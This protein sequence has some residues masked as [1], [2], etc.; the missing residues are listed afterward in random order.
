[1]CKVKVN[2][3]GEYFVFSAQEGE[4]LLKLLR[5]NG[6]SIEAPC[7]G[8]GICG[9]CRI[10]LISGQL[11]SMKSDEKGLLGDRAV[12]KGYRLAC[13]CLIQ[14]DI[15]IL[16][17]GVASEAKIVTEGR[18]R[19]LE[20][21]P[22][23]TKIHSI[24]GKPGLEDQRSDL[25]RILLSFEEHSG[26]TGHLLK[27]GFLRELPEILRRRDFNV[28]LVAE[29]SDIIAIESG[30]TSNS[31]YG[32]AFDIG[33]TTIAAYL[34]DLTTGKRLSV[35]SGMNPQRAYGADVISRINHTMQNDDGLEQLN[36]LLIESINA[37]IGTLCEQTGVKTA[38]I[39]AISF[40][41]NTTMLHLLLG[42]SP[43]SIA[44]A[45]FIP[46]F[47]SA[48]RISAQELGLSINQAGI[49]YILPGVSAYVGADTVGAV[50]ST[51]IHQQ[52]DISLLID[53]GTNG[54]IV[55]GNRDRLLACSAAAGP[56]FEGAN[57]SNGMGSIIGAVSS[58]SLKQGVTFKTI[59]DAKPVG[60]CGTG[61]VD[62]LAGL[63]ETGIVDET[64]RIYTSWKPE[65][66]EQES[67]SERIVS[68]NGANAFVLC[69]ASETLTGN[70]IVLTQKDIREIQNAKA[71]IAVG[72]NVLVKNSGI[73]MSDIK[74]VYLAGGF[75]SY[76]NIRSALRIGLI[77]RELEGKIESVGNA[78]GQGAI[79]ALINKNALEEA[80]KLGKTIKYI[81]LSG[82]K[83]F[84][85]LYME[86]MM[87]E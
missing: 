36:S 8:S 60:I 11:S 67:L 5:N 37:C 80:G 2:R 45:P 18:Q 41:G 31:L 53:I 54:E 83:D 10:K 47:T 87:F 14:S 48:V 69:K 6:I 26:T 71:A 3:S 39:Y 34:L 77:P 35:T 21:C 63:L 49:A 50:L 16:I 24:P 75:G 68:I 55:L 62:L 30:D 32:I 20:L 13:F 57:I 79:D 58:V 1:M 73:S 76:I 81:E 19:S 64:G 29:G 7:N 59:G 78:A 12:E 70:E 44:A 28:T 72:I 23:V 43:R 51:G 27:P 86:C 74:H 40:A 38:D 9:K 46:V 4:N 56:A 17:E 84:N 25:D 33:T 52:A 65:F 15:E 66:P 42:V 82:C 22:L 85:D 61:V